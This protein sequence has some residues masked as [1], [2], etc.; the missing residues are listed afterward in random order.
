MRSTSVVQPWTNTRATWL[1]RVVRPLNTIGAVALHLGTLYTL[2]FVRPHIRDVVIALGA[3]L[4]GMFVISAGYHRYF[5]HRAF[6]TSRVFQALLAF[7]GCFCMQ[8]G[9]LWWAATHRLHHRCTDAPGDP[10][11]PHQ[12][13]FWYSHILW[14]VAVEN[15]GYDSASVRDLE[16]YPELRLI[17]RFCTV[18]LLSFIVF[19]ALV[20]GVRGIGWWFC[21]P[22]CALMHAVMLVNS[23]SHLVGRRRFATA[24]QSRNNAWLALPT[25]GEG[26][27]NNHHRCMSSAR[28]GFYWWEVDPTYWVL[29]LLQRLGI[30]WDLRTPSAEVL[31]EGRMHRPAHGPA[32]Q[33][34]EALSASSWSGGRQSA[35]R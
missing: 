17:E 20:G 12:H 9:V 7:A 32:V 21:V 1:Q 24:D 8:K 15:E 33:S 10:H 19:T 11:S 6:K 2:I 26:W 28:Q 31:A 23:V 4:F 34:G 25:L 30:V 5:S 16:K 22:T 29:L 18:P 3:Y 13:S 27:H 14:T 35:D